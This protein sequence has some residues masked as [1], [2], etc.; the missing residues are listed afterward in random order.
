MFLISV[1]AEYEHNIKE[2]LRTNSIKDKTIFF[3]ESDLNEKNDFSKCRFVITDYNKRIIDYFLDLDKKIIIIADN[4]ETINLKY[5]NNERIDIVNEVANITNRIKNSKE[6]KEKIINILFFR[7][8]VSVALIVLAFVV[9]LT[10]FESKESKKAEP[11]NKNVEKVKKDEE[12]KKKD[13]KKENIVF[14]G[15][16]ITDFYNLEDYYGDLPVVNSGISG[17]KTYDIIG[18]LEDRVYKYNPTKVFILIGTN[19]LLHITDEEI[20]DGIIEIVNEIHKHRKNAKIYVESIYPVNNKTDNDVVIDWMVSERTND[21]IININSILKTKSKS[22]PYKYLNIYD[23]LTN[24]DGDLNLEYTKD[25][26]HMSDKGYEVIT[27]EL[28]K[29][30]ENE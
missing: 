17:N 4:K 14:L 21:R 29:V 9:I 3:T 5:L 7:I 26:L 16:S 25:G 24:E 19:D 8:V 2:I 1:K 23:K 22:N 15:D 12:P 27:K 10:T 6:E 30:I 11:T 18:N 28:M 13:Y 20:V